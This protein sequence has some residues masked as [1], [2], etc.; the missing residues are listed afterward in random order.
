[1]NL[2]IEHTNGNVDVTR[3]HSVAIEVNE[4]YINIV[5]CIEYDMETIE[6][7]PISRVTVDGDVIYDYMGRKERFKV[8]EHG[9]MLLKNECKHR[10]V[11]R[12]LKHYE[13]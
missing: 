1:M 8:Y 13:I 11:E 3:V 2:K 10:L 5:D 9:V 7:E 12:E 4:K 6:L